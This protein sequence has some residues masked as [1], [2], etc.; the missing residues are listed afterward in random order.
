MQN[1]TARPVPAP[2]P[3][4]AASAA[5]YQPGDRLATGGVVLKCRPGVVLAVIPGKR[6]EPFA[7]WVLTAGGVTLSGWYVSDLESALSDFEA[8]A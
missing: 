8:R 6:P 7:T 2:A 1:R 3:I 4:T 5:P